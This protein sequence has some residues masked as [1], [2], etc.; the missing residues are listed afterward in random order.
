MSLSQAIFVFWTSNP[1][2]IQSIPEIGSSKETASQMASYRK[3]MNSEENY[4]PP[5][6]GTQSEK[7]NASWELRLFPSTLEFMFPFS[8]PRLHPSTFHSFHSKQD[9]SSFHTFFPWWETLSPCR[10]LNAGPIFTSAPC[11]AAEE[12][13]YTVGTKCQVEKSVETWLKASTP[14]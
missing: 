6:V 14:K 12:A 10:V 9:F 8:L 7:P 11:D 13:C 5:P 2:G 1:S 3:G 4:A